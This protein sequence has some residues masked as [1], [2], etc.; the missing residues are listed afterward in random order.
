M[1]EKKKVTLYTDGACSGNPGLGGYGGI[2]IYGAVEREYSGAELQTTNNRMEVTA[3]IEG[4]KR[5]KY[6]CKVEVYSDSAYTV[7]AYTNG[8]IYGWKRNGW[9][10]A[11]GK[12]VLNVDL[13]EE[14]YRLT[15]EHEVT[16]IKVAGHAD[17]ELNNRCD[18]L[19]TGAIAEYRKQHPEEL[20]A[21][22][23]L[24]EET[25]E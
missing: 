23:E 22:E 21:L 18:K 5:L 4:L 9:K 2:L 14:L 20:L 25:Q 1:A 7:N 24:K 13:W 19:A 6:P 17:N 8:W 11:D 3:V 10:K 16:F 12:P 15:Q